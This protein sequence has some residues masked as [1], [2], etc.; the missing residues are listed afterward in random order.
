LLTHS[1]LLRKLFWVNR[2]E[3]QVS[4]IGIGIQDADRPVGQKAFKGGRINVNDNRDT[5][6]DL[7]SSAVDDGETVLAIGPHA[8]SVRHLRD[9]PRDAAASS[10]GRQAAY[11]CGL[12]GPVPVTHDG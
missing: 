9:V 8:G 7:R 6:R 4:S 5:R 2:G 11:G 1:V 10:V 12:V 3:Q